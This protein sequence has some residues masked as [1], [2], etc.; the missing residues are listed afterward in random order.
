M[1]DV[2]YQHIEV[3]PLTPVIGAEVGGA[4]LA[5]LDAVVV[6]EIKRAFR[7][8]LVLVFRDQQLTREQHKAFG[9]L[10]GELQTHPAKTHLGVPGDPE[11]FDVNITAS[12]RV[13]NG[14]AWHTDLSCEPVP[15]MASA[16]YITQTPVSGGGDTL[17]ANMQAAFRA[18]SPPVQ[19]MLL[20]LTAHHSG[21]RDLKAYGFVPKP[22]QTY[23]CADHPVVTRHPDTG[24]P[25]LFVNEPFTE[26]IN[27]V[28]P[29]ESAAILDM[30]Y[31]H[32][33]SNTR[34][35]CRVRWRDNTLVLWDNRAVHH[36]AVW[37]YYPETR[38]GERVTMKCPAPPQAYPAGELDAGQMR[39]PAPAW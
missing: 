3:E 29:R 39:Q 36:H 6:D 9:R 35:H 15:P 11:I 22:G 20:E 8:H 16:L 14:E 4:D 37:D 1:T 30:L 24:E 13:A 27:E 32:V 19:R 28:S 38:R 23:P 31:R 26:R 21:Y 2:G 17:F 33:E 12:T 25:V 18:L 5:H 34:L 10:F 7:R